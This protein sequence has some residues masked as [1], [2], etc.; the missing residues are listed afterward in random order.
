MCASYFDRLQLV[1]GNI[2]ERHDVEHARMAGERTRVFRHGIASFRAGIVV[3]WHVNVKGNCGSLKL[4]VKS[5]GYC[6]N[7]T[8]QN[9]G[10][11]AANR[12]CTRTESWDDSAKGS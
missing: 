10:S 2:G 7:S 9:F 3:L 5:R 1:T 12:R 8:D 11:Q 6:F 4:L